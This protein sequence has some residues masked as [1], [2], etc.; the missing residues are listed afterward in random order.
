MCC[1]VFASFL[2]VRRLLGLASAIKKKISERRRWNSCTAKDPEKIS[3]TGKLATKE[4]DARKSGNGR[5]VLEAE[6]SAQRNK[7]EQ[8]Y[9]RERFRKIA[10]TFKRGN[11]F[12]GSSINAALNGQLNSLNFLSDDHRWSSSMGQQEE[13]IDCVLCRSIR[14]KSPERK[15]RAL[16]KF[17]STIKHPHTHAD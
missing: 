1:G 4:L 12:S 15:S 2:L 11:V 17:F 3:F 14:K 8:A 16:M 10:P 9:T 7:Q 6:V 13:I 5:I